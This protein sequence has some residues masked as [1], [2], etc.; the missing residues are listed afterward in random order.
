VSILGIEDARQRGRSLG[1]D[2]D[3]D[4]SGTGSP[5]RLDCAILSGATRK[6]SALPGLATRGART[7]KD[8]GMSLPHSVAGF[9][10]RAPD[11]RAGL[12]VPLRI[13][14][15]VSAPRGALGV[16]RLPWSRCSGGVP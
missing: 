15:D 2:A 11:V 4:L 3:R 6:T 7:S 14:R 8:L 16:S 12:P 9:K 13:D 1:E 10:A 5:D